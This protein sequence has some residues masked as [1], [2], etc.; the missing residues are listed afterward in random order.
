MNKYLKS[1]FACAA[2]SLSLGGYAAYS[3]IEED[4]PNPLAI[5][6][7]GIFA[8]MSRCSFKDYRH[9]VKARKEAQTPAAKI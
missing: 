4:K 2:L 3:H 7:S 9:D 5:A 8:A 6:F 1:A